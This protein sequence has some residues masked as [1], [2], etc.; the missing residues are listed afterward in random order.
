MEDLPDSDRVRSCDDL[1]AYL[2]ELAD[3]VRRGAYP[4]ASANIADFLG[5]A[6]AWMADNRRFRHH[7]GETYPDSPDWKYLAEVLCAAL[8]YE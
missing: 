3:G 7:H 5:T 4:V 1:I 8:V 2:T 6:A